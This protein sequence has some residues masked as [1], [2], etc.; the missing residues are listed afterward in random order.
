[1]LSHLD[2]DRVRIALAAL[3]GAAV[4]GV[5]TLTTKLLTGNHISRQDM[6]L[7]LLNVTAAILC[8]VLTAVVVAPAVAAMIPWVSLRDLPTI[9]F[10]I[11]ALTWELLPFAFDAARNRARREAEHQRGP[12]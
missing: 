8:G 5:F 2:P 6:A 7:A 12:K 9:G 10:L 1:M 3:A 4:Y 11:G